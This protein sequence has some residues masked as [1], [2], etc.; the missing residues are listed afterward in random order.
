MRKIFTL[1]AA[2]FVA[3]GVSAGTKWAASEEAILN[4]GKLQNTESDC[5]IFVGVGFDKFVENTET[6]GYAGYLNGKAS[7]NVS[8]KPSSPVA[9]DLTLATAGTGVKLCPTVKGAIKA[10]VVLNA[11]KDLWVTKKDGTNITSTVTLGNVGESGAAYD[12]AKGSIRSTAKVYGL[13]LNWAAEAAEEYYVFC[14]GSKV[15]FYGYEFTDKEQ[16]EATFSETE[17]QA[18]LGHDFVAPVLNV[19]TEGEFNF[20]YTSSNENVAKVTED[21]VVELVGGGKTVIT[22]TFAGNDAYSP[23]AV[24]Y[25]LKVTDP[26]AVETYLFYNQDGVSATSKTFDGF[27]LE[28]DPVV[29]GKNIDKSN[30][31]TV[32]G[33]EYQGFKTGGSF[34]LKLTA[35]EGRLITAITIYATIN[36]EA[37]AAKYGYWKTINGVDYG[38]Q[39][40]VTGWNYAAPTAHTI[41]FDQAARTISFRNSGTQMAYVIEIS[42]IYGY[43]APA[44]PVPTIKVGETIVTESSV[45][46]KENE[47][48]EVSFEL[49]EGVEVYYNLTETV[50]PEK[51]AAEDG[52][53][54][55]KYTEP[56]MISK[57]S[58]LTYYSVVNGVESE[59]ATFTVTGGTTAIT[60]INAD[61]NAPVEYF[62]LQGIRVANPENG[63]FVRRQGN[64]VTKVVK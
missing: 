33:K 48:A 52:L 62:N 35:P 43:E 49:A 57:A 30:A 12:A 40:A 41:D 63:V 36:A 28:C 55:T 19:V 46:L 32:N 47:V 1:L 22:A 39:Y 29:E 34:G 44:A 10:Y 21:G 45:D 60:E 53:E 24:S 27:T 38:E 13:E 18:V 23:L 42:T 37:N 15:S 3:V 64:T 7:A 25:T 59:K 26:N 14:T 11:A 6:P 16:V 4:K 56:I 5:P 2:L 31:L 61:A 9:P 50:A 54:Y 20:V 17:V 8:Y 51:A 58:T